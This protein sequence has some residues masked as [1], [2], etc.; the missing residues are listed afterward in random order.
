[1]QVK[2]PVCG[3]MVDDTTAPARSTYEGTTYYFCSE[4]CKKTF[5]EAPARYATPVGAST[6]E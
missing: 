4:Q 5:D 2:D 1:M 3:M 6:K